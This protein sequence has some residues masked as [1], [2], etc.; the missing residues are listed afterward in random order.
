MMT[1]DDERGEGGKKCPNLDDVICERPLMCYVHITC[2]AREWLSTI[3][4]YTRKN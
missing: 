2:S 3:Y 1:I 4:F